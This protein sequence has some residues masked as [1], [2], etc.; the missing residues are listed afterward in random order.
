MSYRKL[1]VDGEQY[2]WVYGRDY[3]KIKGPKGSTAVKLWE[4]FGLTE[5]KYRAAFNEQCGEI[6]FDCGPGD[7]NVILTPGRVVQYIKEHGL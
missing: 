5:T 6:Y 1:S 3:L 2:G 7:P 4:F